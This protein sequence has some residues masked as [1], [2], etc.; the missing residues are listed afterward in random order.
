[1]DSYPLRDPEDTTGFGFKSETPG[2]SGMVPTEIID[3]NPVENSSRSR[4]MPGSERDPDI[5]GHKSHSGV[6]VARAVGDAIRSQRKLHDSTCAV[7][8]SLELGITAR[9]RGVSNIVAT[10]RR[11][12]H[13]GRSLGRA[14]RDLDAEVGCFATGV[15]GLNDELVSQG[16]QRS[17]P[18]EY[19]RRV[20]RPPLG[21]PKLPRNPEGEIQGP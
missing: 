10:S 4:K 16:E 19:R 20:R 17:E 14:D 21:E 9:E 2:P 5:L 18:D 11:L 3:E 12:D 15:F 7:L 8:R 6:A 1:M 13:A